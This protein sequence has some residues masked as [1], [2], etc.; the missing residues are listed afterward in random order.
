MKHCEDGTSI[1]H[2]V[3]FTEDTVSVFEND[4]PNEQGISFVI[5]DN[6]LRLDPSGENNVLYVVAITSSSVTLYDG[7]NDVYYYSLTDA[8]AHAEICSDDSSSGDTIAITQEM[9]SG[10]TFLSSFR[11]R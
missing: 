5:S 9:L 1:T 2:K 10:K 4:E 8:E 11:Y 6:A 7:E 3:V